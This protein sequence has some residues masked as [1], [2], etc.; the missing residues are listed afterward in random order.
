VGVEGVDDPI[1]L[2]VVVEPLGR[3]ERREARIA[4]PDVLDRP[5]RLLRQVLVMGP[6]IA[7]W[8]G[9]IELVASPRHVDV[10]G[11]FEPGQ[12]ALEPALAEVAPGAGDIGPDLDA[13][14]GAA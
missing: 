5:A 3:R 7:S 2:E 14:R 6:G 11:A 8:L 1:A 12:R 4:G 9:R 13:H 10:I